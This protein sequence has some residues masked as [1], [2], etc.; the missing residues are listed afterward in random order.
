MSCVINSRVHESN[1][2]EVEE[3]LQKSHHMASQQPV[4]V[5]IFVSHVSGRSM[6]TVA[7]GG[8]TVSRHFCMN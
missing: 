2:V 6:D 8:S 5:V 7:L 3:Q 4:V 1:N